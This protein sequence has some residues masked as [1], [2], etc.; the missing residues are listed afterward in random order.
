MAQRQ[1]RTPNSKCRQ[2]RP[3]MLKLN[4]IR[5]PALVHGQPAKSIMVRILRLPLQQCC[6]NDHDI[7]TARESSCLISCLNVCLPSKHAFFT[8]SSPVSCTQTHARTNPNAHA[9]FEQN[10]DHKQR[11][12]LKKLQTQT[13]FIIPFTRSRIANHVLFASYSTVCI[14]FI[15][16]KRR[17]EACHCRHDN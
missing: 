5:L 13:L 6:L 2:L 9:E 12:K 11:P 4:L 7:E 3:L 1:A 15:K 8:L 17:G 14:C 10:S 16:R